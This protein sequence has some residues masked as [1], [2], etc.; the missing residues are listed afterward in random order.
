[1]AVESKGEVTKRQFGLLRRRS[2]GGGSGPQ[3]K[4]MGISIPPAA[5]NCIRHMFRPSLALTPP[6]RPLSDFTTTRAR[7]PP[8]R[9]AGGCQAVAVAHEEGRTVFRVAAVGRA[10]IC[11]QCKRLLLIA[12]AAATSKSEGQK[13]LFGAIFEASGQKKV[14]PS[15]KPL[16]LKCERQ[17][18]GRRRGRAT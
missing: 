17:R 12:R 13:P 18:T 11:F 9:A 15:L 5:C 2:E 16:H 3:W 1:M 6:S 7:E 14:S 4:W 10:H 8:Q